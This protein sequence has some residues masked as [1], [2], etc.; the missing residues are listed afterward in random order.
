M[1]KRVKHQTETRIEA[2]RLFDAGFGVSFAAAELGVSSHT[3]GDW[4]S[5]HRRGRLLQL[6]DMTGNNRYSQQQKIQ[7]VEEFLAGKSKTEVLAEYGISTRGVFNKWLTAYR[8][9]GP[10]ALLDK[11]K[12]RPPITKDHSK[13]SL[14]DRTYQLEMENAV[15]KKFQ[16]LMDEQEAQSKKRRR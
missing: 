15:L 3:I 6:G 16:A 8:A 4:Q 11:P 9:G 7:A 2:A 1:D 12:G 14:E 10:S 5:S 13:Q